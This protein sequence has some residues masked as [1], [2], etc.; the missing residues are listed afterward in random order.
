MWVLIVYPGEERPIG[1]AHEIHGLLGETARDV[2]I[3]I[4][5]QFEGTV[6]FF[7]FAVPIV[8]AQTDFVTF[9]PELGQFVV[10]EEV[11]LAEHA[12][13]IASLLEGGDQI[14]DLGIN[15]GPIIAAT[16]FPDVGAGR[17][18]DATGGAERRLAVAIIEPRSLRSQAV[19]V[20]GC[21]GRMTVATQV[22]G[23]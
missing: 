8:I 20:L 22:V 7:V 23:S 15:R 3:V 1:T 14:G 5:F 2:V 12:R 4:L 17:E 18:T 19:D 16:V 10:G 13:T 9:V 11:V 21:N 6:G